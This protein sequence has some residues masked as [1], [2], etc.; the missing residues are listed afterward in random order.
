MSTD[1]HLTLLE[2]IRR[3]NGISTIESGRFSRGGR[4]PADST[5]G[6]VEISEKEE[7]SKG[8]IDSASRA[9]VENTQEEPIH[10]LRP[11][12]KDRKGAAIE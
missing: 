7:N 8:C 6:S 10:D 5:S 11:R 4:R 12:P 2:L 3:L 1:L 9:T